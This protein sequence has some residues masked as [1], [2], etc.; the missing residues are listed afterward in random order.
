MAPP[1]LAANAPVTQVVDPVEIHFVKA[2][3]ND[4]DVLVADN[5]LHNFFEAALFALPVD[6]FFIDVDEPLQTDLRFDD[7]FATVVKRNVVDIIFVNAN[8]QAFFARNLS[9]SSGEVI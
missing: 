5:R 3:R 1:D 8:Q 2:L 7:T 4:G 6:G 9:Y